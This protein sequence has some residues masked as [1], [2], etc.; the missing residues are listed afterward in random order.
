MYCRCSANSVEKPVNGERCKPERKPSTTERASNSSE[1][2][3][4]STSGARNRGAPE[5][6]CAVCSFDEPFVPV[7]FSLCQ[8]IFIFRFCKRRRTGSVSD[9]GLDQWTFDQLPGRLRSP[10]RNVCPWFISK[11][12]NSI[13]I[14]ARARSRPVS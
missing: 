9:L 5:Y 14:W 4:A 1:L 2:I 7:F 12:L 13:P 11:K 3:R 10:Y 8:F 6:A